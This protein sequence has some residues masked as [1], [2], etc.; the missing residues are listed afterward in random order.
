MLKILLKKV[1][2]NFELK[3][4][5]QRKWTETKCI[6]DTGKSVDV[7]WCA[8]KTVKG[9]TSIILLLITFLSCLHIAFHLIKGSQW[10]SKHGLNSLVCDSFGDRCKCDADS[11]RALNNKS[12]DLPGGKPLSDE[13]LWATI[14]SAVKPFQTDKSGCEKLADRNKGSQ[15][16]TLTE[17]HGV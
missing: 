11:S 2:T 12:N 17:V 15:N 13:N 9:L 1:M 7:V 3:K 8:Q 10:I 16:N 5:E 6:K 14:E 4:W